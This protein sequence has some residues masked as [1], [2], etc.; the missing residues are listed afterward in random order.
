MNR[1][2]TRQ[3]LRA[4]IRF[5]GGLI[6][7]AATGAAVAALMASLS[8]ASVSAV[9][10]DPFR[11]SGGTLA[12]GCDPWKGDTDLWKDA[13]GDGVAEPFSYWWSGQ[14]RFWNDTNAHGCWHNDEST[15]TGDPARPGG[16][17]SAGPST[18]IYFQTEHWNA[19]SAWPGVLFQSTGCLGVQAVVYTPSGLYLTTVKYWHITPVSGVIGTNWTYHFDVSGYGKAYRQIG[20]GAYWN[21]GTN[22]DGYCTVFG[23]HLHQSAWEGWYSTSPLAGTSANRTGNPSSSLEFWFR[24]GN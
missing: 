2:R 3:A 1:L 18:A 5:F 4:S 6:G 7:G 17:I 24:W 23:Y 14:S 15:L 11:L 9:E 13:T 22:S 16:D 21:S 12:D 20:S 10:Y 19:F 8:A